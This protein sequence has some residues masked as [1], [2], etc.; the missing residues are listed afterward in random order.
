M[1][2][3]APP[4]T[5]A[6]WNDAGL[7]REVAVDRDGVVYALGLASRARYQRAMSMAAHIARLTGIKVEQV[8]LDL[9]GDYNG[10]LYA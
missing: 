5:S 6:T 9:A 1:T 2:T 7:L 10:Q 3:T 4:L 8:I